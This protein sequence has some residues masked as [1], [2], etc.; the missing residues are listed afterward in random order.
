MPELVTDE[1][2]SRGW[3][4]R[5][6]LAKE[7][8]ASPSTQTTIIDSLLQSISQQQQAAQVV[9]ALSRCSDATGGYVQL[10]H[11]YSYVPVL[12]GNDQTPIPLYHFVEVIDEFVDYDK[13]KEALPTLSYAQINGAIAFLRKAS[14]YNPQGLDFDLMEDEAEANDPALLNEIKKALADEETSRVLNLD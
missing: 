12:I 10:K 1:D 3:Y 2:I 13:V 8:T 6:L 4:L 7:N 5:R 11:E 14:Q 9:L